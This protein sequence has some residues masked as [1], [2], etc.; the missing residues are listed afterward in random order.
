M[1][2][3]DTVEVH[4]VLRISDLKVDFRKHSL[5]LIGGK[6]EQGK[7][8]AINAILMTL[9]GK[10]GMDWPEVALKEGEDHGECVVELSMD[11]EGGDQDVFPDMASVTVKRVWDRDPRTGTIKE[12]V[13]ITDETGQKSAS[14]QQILNDLF[15]SRAMDPLKLADTDRSV[16]RQMLMELVGLDEAFDELDEQ[17]KE[18]FTE[19]AAVN[20]QGAAAKTKFDEQSYDETAADAEVPISELLDELNVAEKNNQR[21]MQVR[22]IAEV[23]AAQVQAGI[24]DLER[25][26]AAL[27][28]AEETLTKRQAAAKD[29]AANAASVSLSEIDPIRARIDGLEAEN[30]KVRANQR[31]KDAEKELTELRE[32]RDEL[33]GKLDLIPIRQQ[34]LLANADWPVEELS[35]DSKGV[36][37]RG[38][39]ESQASKAERIRLWC[40]VAAALNPKLKLL[41]FKDGNDLDYKSMDELD[42]FLKE[43][44]FQAIVEYVTRT[45]D[46]EDRCVV[47]LEDGHALAP[48]ETVEV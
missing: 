15:K 21:V 44:G 22:Q 40:R 12:S 8:S 42:T 37:Y 35:V 28:L 13:T 36:L 20:K 41:I 32:L 38:L 30:A 25:K 29:A 1:A 26:K 14:P 45:T 43:S 17:Y 19:R 46:D 23:A 18:L 11:P 2:Q 3:I 27:A 34:E 33:Q 31:Y 16:Q 6:N 4:N 48:K 24:D 7:T 47:V 9:C 5:A 39:P 10:R